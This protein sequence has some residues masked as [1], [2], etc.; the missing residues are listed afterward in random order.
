MAT[1][2]SLRW[3]VFSVGFSAGL[4]PGSEACAERGFTGELTCS[5]CKRLQE[6]LPSDSEQQ[7]ASEAKELLLECSACCQEKGAHFAKAFL[8]YSPYLLDVDQDLDDFVKRKAPGIEHLVMKP[9]DGNR[10][11]LQFLREGESEKDSKE[12]VSIH[13]WKSDEINDFLKIRLKV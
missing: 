12:F 1:W 9:V 13:K 6:F 5:T 4:A 2:N 3:L 8:Y 11:T 7:G 10:P